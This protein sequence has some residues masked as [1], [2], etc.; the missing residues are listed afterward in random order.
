MIVGLRIVLMLGM[1]AVFAPLLAYLI[2]RNRRFLELAYLAG[3]LTFA[4]LM[5]FGL[6]YLFERALLLL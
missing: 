3:K 2:T 4:V 5:A 1:F 6:F